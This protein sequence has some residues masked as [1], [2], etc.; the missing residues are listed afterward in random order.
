[1]PPKSRTVPPPK[2]YSEA[3]KKSSH[4]A[5]LERFKKQA[6]K[7]YPE[8][9]PRGM[10]YHEHLQKFG[11]QLA[12]TGYQKYLMRTY[13]PAMKDA[14]DEKMKESSQAATQ[15]SVAQNASNRN[16]TP[17]FQRGLHGDQSEKVCCYYYVLVSCNYHDVPHADFFSAG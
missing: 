7:E 12:L 11:R 9:L 13:L 10:E 15:T 1:M 4:D 16:D 14:Y 2:E 17:R 8:W 5:E 3:R 6:Q